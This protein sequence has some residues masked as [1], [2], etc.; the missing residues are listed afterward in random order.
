MKVATA[1]LQIKDRVKGATFVKRQH[2]IN[3]TPA[4]IEH[5]VMAEYPDACVLFVIWTK[6]G[7]NSYYEA[8]FTQ[9][10]LKRGIKEFNLPPA[11]FLKRELDYY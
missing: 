1:A 6:E 5:F 7:N 8:N 4:D 3:K 9:Q 10:I 11:L 2:C